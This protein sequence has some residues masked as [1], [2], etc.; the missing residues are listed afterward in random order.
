MTTPCS[1]QSSPVKM[2]HC[3]AISILRQ[4]KPAWYIFERRGYHSY[5][6]Q[7]GLCPLQ[8]NVAWKIL[9]LL[10]KTSFPERSSF[11]Q[12]HT[13]TISC[14]PPGPQYNYN[15]KNLIHTSTNPKAMKHSL[16]N[17]IELQRTL[18]YAL[19]ANKV[20]THLHFLSLINRAPSNLINVYCGVSRRYCC[21][22]VCLLRSTCEFPCAAGEASTVSAVCQ[23]EQY[24][25][26]TNPVAYLSHS[27]QNLSF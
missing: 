19:R 12:L 15:N 21:F 27:A 7:S 22:L 4:N 11:V 17:P 8:T 26:N 20:Q 1:F 6:K 2:W 16:P 24:L 3:T 18:H 25:F 10:I 23:H 14:R 5:Q 13:L 9:Y